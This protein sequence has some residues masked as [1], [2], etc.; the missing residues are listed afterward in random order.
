MG[1]WG[2][3]RC[4]TAPHM[5][6]TQNRLACYIHGIYMQLST[7]YTEQLFVTGRPRLIPFTCIQP[8][9]E[10]VLRQTTLNLCTGSTIHPCTHAGIREMYRLANKAYIGSFL[11][12]FTYSS[13]SPALH[14]QP[15]SPFTLTSDLYPFQRKKV[16]LS[17]GVNTI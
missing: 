4:C 10:V 14:Y 5:T 1:F 7:T 9:Y 8:S 16:S 13:P 3:L 17:E 15:G 6:Q 11:P 12:L 2:N